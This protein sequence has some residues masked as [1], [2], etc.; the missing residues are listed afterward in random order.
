[1]KG[2]RTKSDPIDH[3]ETSE[4]VTGMKIVFGGKGRPPTKLRSVAG[5]TLA[6]VA[7][8]GGSTS[9]AQAAQPQVY[10]G[11]VLV[12]SVKPLG[13][14]NCGNTIVGSSYGVTLH[15]GADSAT[16]KR[17]RLAIL[18]DQFAAHMA[19]DNQAT[20][21]YR[22]FDIDGKVFYGYSP[23]LAGGDVTLLPGGA[24]PGAELAL[25]MKIPQ[26]C[27]YGLF[28]VASLTAEQ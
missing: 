9:L 18:S 17:W 16:N 7:L 14:G 11:R 12:T 23:I 22:F 3:W 27:E 2:E 1:M 20:T 25:T 21:S 13:T 6:A 10:L 5:A 28:I 26:V 24:I 15:L 8:F 19:K 4:R